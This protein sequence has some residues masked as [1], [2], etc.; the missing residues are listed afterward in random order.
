M[1]NL[2]LIMDECAPQ[3]PGLVV[4][5]G[6]GAVAEG[7]A[8]RLFH[9]GYHV[10]LALHANQEKK[11]G[12]EHNPLK[13][14][15]FADMALEGIVRGEGITTRL[16]PW[17]PTP[18]RLQAV[19]LENALPVVYAVQEEDSWIHEFMPAALV[20]ASMTKCGEST[21]RNPGVV[22]IG[23]GPG[24]IAGPAP[25]ELHGARD[26]AQA[27]IMVDAVV[28]TA[29]T[30]SLGT[31]ILEGSAQNSAKYNEDFMP[32][33][34]PAWGRAIGG[35]VLEALLMFGITPDRCP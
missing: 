7:V 1:Q 6:T 13:N 35:G 33:M 34:L 24:F 20:D 29:F 15:N 31:V 21:K 3:L 25:D 28:E 11:Q 19:I 12:E 4:I 23:L 27:G 22:T 9:S 26:N 18:K 8:A 14:A 16:I 30:P 32:D 10:M 2:E 17:P 5:K